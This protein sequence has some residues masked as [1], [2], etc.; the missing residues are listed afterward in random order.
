MLASS[1]FQNLI[2]LVVPAAFLLSGRVVNLPPPLA[3]N[4]ADPHEQE[5]ST[6]DSHPGLPVNSPNYL[7]G[8]PSEPQQTVPLKK[9]SVSTSEVAPFTCSMHPEIEQFNP[10]NCPICGMTLAEKSAEGSRR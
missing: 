9:L 5:P 10:G 1:N 2:A 7:S 3:S 6:A 8:V 4:P